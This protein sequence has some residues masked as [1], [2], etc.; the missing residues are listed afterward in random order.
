MFEKI[1]FMRVSSALCLRGVGHC[2]N[3]AADSHSELQGSRF[4][5]NIY[6]SFVG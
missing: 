4:F 2:N 6:T 3:D 5:W 1:Q